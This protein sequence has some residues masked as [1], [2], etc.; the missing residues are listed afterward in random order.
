MPEPRPA[1]RDP[2]EKTIEVLRWMI[3]APADSWGVRELAR[4][5]ERPPS[6]VYR[7]LNRLEAQGL[8][9]LDERSGRYSLGLE[10]HR[11]AAKVASGFSLREVAIPTLVALRDRFNETAFLGLLDPQRREMM[12]ASAI[13]ST[14]ELR[15]VVTIN[16]WRPLYLGAS[17]LAILA[18]MDE[19]AL[20]QVLAGGTQR[21][22]KTHIR[23]QVQRIRETGYALTIGE[24]V[25]DA[26]GIAAPVFNAQ[27][28][29]LGSVGVTLPSSRFGTASEPKFAASV[30]AAADEVTKRL[31]Y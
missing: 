28:R 31:V 6:T 15:Y 23:A 22:A 8:V 4:A 5:I 29:V 2:V 19:Q 27:R 17:G 1:P 26:V 20:E 25:P 16:E 24:R 21:V 11:L 12:M 14:H 3:D 7:A 18:F 13:E 10:M 30:I 9:A